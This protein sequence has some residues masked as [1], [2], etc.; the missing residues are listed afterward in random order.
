MPFCS[1]MRWTLPTAGEQSVGCRSCSTLEHDNLINAVEKLGADGLLE[2]GKHLLL[3]LA[4][5]LK[6]TAD[7]VHLVAGTQALLV[8]NG[9]ELLLNE[10]AAEIGGHDDDGVLEVDVRPIVGQTR[11]PAPAA[12]VE[13]IGV[14]FL[15]LVEK[16]YA[17]GLAAHGFRE[18]FHPHRNRHIREARQ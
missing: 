14:R 4:G 11:R 6:A 13:D 18:L 9:V 1:S 3:G 7:D 5:A 15:D 10:A 16:H 8:L 2:Q 12:D 17:V